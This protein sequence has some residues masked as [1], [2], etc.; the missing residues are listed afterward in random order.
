MKRAGAALR[1]DGDDDVQ[2]ELKGPGNETRA[3][4]VN[5]WGNMMP[6]GGPWRR[7]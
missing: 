7:G 1:R 2:A 4:Q 5:P 3:L 6:F